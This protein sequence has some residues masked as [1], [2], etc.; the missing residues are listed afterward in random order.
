[1]L[2][3][4]WKGSCTSDSLIPYLDAGSNLS[5]EGG[6][7]V[8]S[9]KLFLQISFSAHM[10]P[11]VLLKSLACILFFANS[12]LLYSILRIGFLILV[13]VCT[14]L[15]LG[16]SRHTTSSLFYVFILVYYLLCVNL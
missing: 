3:N 7:L 9:L 5:V 14:K 1:M 8:V 11:E 6:K 16:I 2:C 13:V 12:T 15:L 10:T 4:I